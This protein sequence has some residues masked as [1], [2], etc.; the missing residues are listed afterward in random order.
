MSMVL[1]LLVVVL[2]ASYLWHLWMG[3]LSRGKLAAAD[4]LKLL[5]L[6]LETALMLFLARILIPWTPLTSWAWVAGV[7]AVGGGAALAVGRAPDLPWVTA[8][9]RNRMRRRQV[10]TPLYAAVL[11]VVTAVCYATLL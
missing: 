11:V 4:R 5:T 6:V 9:S 1:T 8:S 10:L 3:V 7:A 2:G